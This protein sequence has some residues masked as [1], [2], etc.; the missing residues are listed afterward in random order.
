M[1]I[2]QAVPLIKEALVNLDT[3]ATHHIAR[4]LRAQPGDTLFLFNGQGGEYGTAL[5]YDD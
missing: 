4:V 3:M 1:R 2:Y 5:G